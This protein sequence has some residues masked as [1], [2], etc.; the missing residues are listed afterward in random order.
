MSP[1][2]QRA[3]TLRGRPHSCRLWFHSNTSWTSNNLS[4]VGPVEPPRFSVPTGSCRHKITWLCAV[5]FLDGPEETK[6]LRYGHLRS[7]PVVVDDGVRTEREPPTLRAALWLSTRPTWAPP[8]GL[9]ASPTS[10]ERVCRVVA[11]Q[12]IAMRSLLL[13]AL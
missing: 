12:D 10:R 6:V 1:I 11:V 4:I 13:Q 3:V 5:S 9:T 8:R 2:A 7:A